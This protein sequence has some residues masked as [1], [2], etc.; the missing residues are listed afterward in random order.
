MSTPSACVYT[1]ENIIGRSVSE[2]LCVSHAHAANIRPAALSFR[3][4][5]CV[6]TTPGCT[7]RK[8][9]STHTQ[10]PH[11]CT[12]TRDELL[13]LAP[14]S[15]PL[16]DGVNACETRWLVCVCVRVSVVIIRTLNATGGAI[17]PLTRAPYR[18]AAAAAIAELNQEVTFAHI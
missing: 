12:H 14:F 16:P 11:P 10:R 5:G 13:F 8:C 17:N 2:C 6:S 9:V 4:G 1:S 3:S 15:I 18:M 7:Q